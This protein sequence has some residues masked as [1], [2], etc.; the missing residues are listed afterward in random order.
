M[1]TPKLLGFYDRTRGGNKVVGEKITY[2]LIFDSF[3]KSSWPL[4]R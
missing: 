4:P 1:D 2:L 3:Q